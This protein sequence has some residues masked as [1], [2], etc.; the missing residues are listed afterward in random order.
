MNAAAPT[1]AHDPMVRERHQ[2]GFPPGRPRNSAG[3]A[4]ANSHGLMATSLAL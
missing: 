4:H 3:A 1:G 2:S